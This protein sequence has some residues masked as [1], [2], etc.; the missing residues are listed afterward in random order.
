MDDQRQPGMQ[1]PLEDVLTA[2][3]EQ[4][5]TALT[6]AAQMKALARQLLAENEQLRAELDKLRDGASTTGGDVSPSSAIAARATR[7]AEP[8]RS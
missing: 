2:V 3:E 4:R 6:E 8:D 7:T 5:N 1:V